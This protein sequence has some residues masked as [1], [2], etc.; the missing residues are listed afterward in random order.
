VLE[1]VFAA[2]EVVIDLLEI[3]LLLTARRW[4]LVARLV[5]GLG[6]HSAA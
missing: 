2:V 6:R 3:A 4:T 5:N 1:V